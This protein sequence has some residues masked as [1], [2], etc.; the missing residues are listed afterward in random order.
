LTSVG[1]V[2]HHRRHFVVAFDQEARCGL[3]DERSALH[4][5]SAWHD[6]HDQHGNG[7]ELSST[8]HTKRTVED[9]FDRRIFAFFRKSEAA[10]A[11][12]DEIV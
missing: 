8:Q 5:D 11:N 12:H 10:I 2:S 7:Q 6:E 3:I 9:G 1:R 4:S